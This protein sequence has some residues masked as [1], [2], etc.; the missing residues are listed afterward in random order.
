MAIALVGGFN[1]F[2]RSVVASWNLAKFSACIISW[3]FYQ[4]TKVT[5]INKVIIF[6]CK[7]S[8]YSWS[9][10]V[11]NISNILTD[12][13]ECSNGG[14]V[15]QQRCVNVQGSYNCECYYGYRLNADR[16]TCSQ[17]KVLCVN[18]YTQYINVCDP[19]SPF[20]HLNAHVNVRF[21]HIIL[22]TSF[23]I[24]LWF[25][26]NRACLRAFAEQTIVI[27]LSILTRF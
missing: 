16:K 26:N 20:L 12:V 17:G 10:N 19:H 9:E 4:I 3:L 6:L 22:E 21:L 7:Y 1:Q 14:G 11:R 27:L 13:N 23:N 25:R 5:I 8:N 24:M 15:C 2:N 18:M